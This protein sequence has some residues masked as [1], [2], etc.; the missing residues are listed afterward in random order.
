MT[1]AYFVDIYF[2]FSL[3]LY[4]LEYF[5]KNMYLTIIKKTFSSSFMSSNDYSEEYH[6]IF[7]SKF[8][9]C[10]G[11]IEI[12]RSKTCGGNLGITTNI[13]ILDITQE[14]GI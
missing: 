3:I 9:T 11:L 8:I 12:I 1:V 6:S 13:Y 10:S 4:K 2:I 7:I 5:H 14:F